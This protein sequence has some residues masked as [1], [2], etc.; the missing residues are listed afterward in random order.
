MSLPLTARWE[1]GHVPAPHSHEA[2]TLDA[3]KSPRDWLG[4]G[5]GAPV[6]GK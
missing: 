1:Y 4:V 6:E 5:V 2:R 3:L